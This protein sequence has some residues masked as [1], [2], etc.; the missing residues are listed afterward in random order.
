MSFGCITANIILQLFELI[1]FSQ[2]L[3]WKCPGHVLGTGT[4][5]KIPGTELDGRPFLLAFLVS[6][7]SAACPPSKSR[8]RYSKKNKEKENTNEPNL[9]NWRSDN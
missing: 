1:G 2:L 6:H 5:Q 3:S 4:F 9:R 7:V 8:V